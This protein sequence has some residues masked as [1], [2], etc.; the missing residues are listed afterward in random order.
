MIEAG[1]FFTET[2]D[3]F[4][5]IIWSSYR[6][7]SQIWHLCVIYVEGF[8]HQRW[9]M[10]GFQLFC[11][12]RD[13]CCMW[14]RKYST[15]SATPDF[16]PFVE[17]MVSPIHYVY[18]YIDIYGYRYIYPY[19]DKPI[20]IYA[21]IWIYIYISIYIYNIY[22]YI[23]IYPYTY[24]YTQIYIYTYIIYIST[25]YI[26]EFVSFSTIFMD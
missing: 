11:V 5:E 25:P 3:Y 22:I 24:I 13:G 23:Y 9:H 12:N 6:P 26:T 15:L 1:I 4:S 19:R 21:Y 16:T 8:V 17:F 14:G 20:Y 2:S 18:I 7:C 10:T